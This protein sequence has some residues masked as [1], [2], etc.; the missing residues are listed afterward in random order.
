M[1]DVGVKTGKWMVSTPLV[2]QA[3][4][5]FIFDEH[6][7]IEDTKDGGLSDLLPFWDNKALKRFAADSASASE[8]APFWTGSK[9]SVAPP[10]SSSFKDKLHCYCHCKGTQF[11]ISRPQLGYKTPDPNKEYDGQFDPKDGKWPATNC[12]CNDC[13]LA[14][15]ADLFP[16]LFVPPASISLPDGSTMPQPPHFGSLTEHQSSKDVRRYFCGN[17]GATVFFDSLKRPEVIDVA[18]GIVDANSG[19]RAE[20]WLAWSW[21]KPD[22]GEYA[23]NRKMHKEILQGY[24]R[25][26]EKSGENVND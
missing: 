7:F 24:R 13:R 4:E 8:L 18:V 15:A 21:D 22:Y 11:Y 1:L 19:A 2:K 25:W 12:V 16:W 9:I 3:E 26:N 20:D 17:C 10:A 5:L 6:F 14:G 23:A